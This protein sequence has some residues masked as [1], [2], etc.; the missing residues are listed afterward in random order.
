[1]GSDCVRIICLHQ[2]ILTL[3]FAIVTP[4]SFIPYTQSNN[5]YALFPQEIHSIN[6]NVT[7]ASIKSLH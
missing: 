5:E 4:K 6:G 7:P 1:M 3:H 2:R